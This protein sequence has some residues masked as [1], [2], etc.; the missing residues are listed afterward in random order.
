MYMLLFNRFTFLCF[1]CLYSIVYA[2]I[3]L[4]CGLQHLI[5]SLSL[6]CIG[7]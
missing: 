7:E 2:C 1:N 3:Y 4:A 5:K 6:S